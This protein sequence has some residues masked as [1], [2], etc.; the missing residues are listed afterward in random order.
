MVMVV[1]SMLLAGIGIHA[2]DATISENT[3]HMLK[4]N[5]GVTDAEP[6]KNLVDALEYRLTR[7][8]RH[9]LNQDM[10][11]ECVRV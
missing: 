1:V 10:R 5:R 2:A 11:A 3:G 8:S 6:G 4:L 7:R 9:V